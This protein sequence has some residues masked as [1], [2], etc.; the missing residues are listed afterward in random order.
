MDQGQFLRGL[1]RGFTS[2]VVGGPADIAEQ[3]ANLGIAG[4]GYLGNKLGLLDA[5]EMPQLLE[6]SPIT[7]ETFAG[8]FVIDSGSGKYTKAAEKSLGGIPVIPRGPGKVS[9]ADLD[10]LLAEA[11]PARTARKGLIRSYVQKPGGLN[12]PT[13][14]VDL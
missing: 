14:I 9:T 8:A 10:N 13:R 6:A 7:P 12:A 1:L 2:D 5:S 3:L 4:Y 11:G